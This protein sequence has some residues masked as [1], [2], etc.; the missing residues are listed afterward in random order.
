MEMVFVVAA[1]EVIII[2]IKVDK[3]SI[4]MTHRPTERRTDGR[5]TQPRGQSHFLGNVDFSPSWENTSSTAVHQDHIINWE[6]GFEK[7]TNS[8]TY[9]RCNGVTSNVKPMTLDTPKFSCIFLAQ[10]RETCRS[11]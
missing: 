9:L 8:V 2:V 6:L 1:V 4:Y 11:Y 3:F 7:V 5:T 10:L